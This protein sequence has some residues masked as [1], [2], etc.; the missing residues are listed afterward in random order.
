MM[1]Y[2]HGMEIINLKF[3]F[4]I[5]YNMLLNYK[6]KPSLYNVPSLISTFNTYFRQYNNHCEFSTSI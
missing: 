2:I 5:V 4:T 1:K 6:E 3:S